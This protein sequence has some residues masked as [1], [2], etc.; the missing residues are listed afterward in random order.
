[1]PT[2]VAQRVNAPTDR[3]PAGTTRPQSPAGRLPLVPAPRLAAGGSE[4]PSGV[5]RARPRASGKLLGLSDHELVQALGADERESPAGAL[6]AVRHLA[7]P[8]T[9]GRAADLPPRSP[10][11]ARA[12]GRRERPADA[13]PERRDRALGGSACAAG[14]GDRGDAPGQRL[15]DGGRPRSR[16]GA[17]GER[18]HRP[19]RAR[20]RHPGGGAPRSAARAGPHGDGDGGRRRCRPSR[21]LARLAPENRHGGL[22]AGGAALRL[23]PAQLVPRRAGTDR[24]GARADGDRGGGG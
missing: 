23:R 1:M 13:A 15:R 6:H 11:P 7:D 2:H 8:S 17:R 16:T 12:G 18:D 19:E 5:P 4:R 21:N 22:R 14:R 9:G 3:R 10:L 20:G 24:R